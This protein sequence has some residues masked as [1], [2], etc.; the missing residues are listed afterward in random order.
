MFE[1]AAADEKPSSAIKG[2]ASYKIRNKIAR[3][4]NDKKPQIQIPK[5]AGV[6][7]DTVTARS[8]NSVAKFTSMFEEKNTRNEENEQK[9]SKN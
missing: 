6:S 4:F 7:R 2:N 9:N 8:N 3:M 5:A 1:Q